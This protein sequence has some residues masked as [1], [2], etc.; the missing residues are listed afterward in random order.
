[1]Q[2]HHADEAS[3]RHLVTVATAHVGQDDANVFTDTGWF[4]LENTR[5]PTADDLAALQR[6]LGGTG[7]LVCTVY[8]ARCHGVSLVS[9]CRSHVFVKKDPPSGW[10]PILDPSVAQKHPLKKGDPERAAVENAFLSTLRP[11]R[12]RESVEVVRVERIQNL[13]MWQSYVVKRQT[14][15]FRETGEISSE[16]DAVQ[17]K[18]QER[19]ER[20]W[21]FHGSN[22][23]VVDKILQQGFNRSFCGKN[24]TVYGKGVYFA[25]DA[26]YSADRLYSVPDSKGR[27]HMLACRV[28]VGE[29]CKGK[30]S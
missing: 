10:D 13:A 22:F 11:P 15:C 3:A 17:R 28:V 6:N 5:I 4:E 14:I 21:L 2:L 7:A 19:F 18:V 20:K 27:Q 29:Y 24:A 1:M 12:F 9:H 26:C 25:R 8:I 16:D 30:V 23:D